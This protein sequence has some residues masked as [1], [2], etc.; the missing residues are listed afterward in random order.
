MSCFGYIA[1]IIGCFAVLFGTTQTIFAADPCAKTDEGCWRRE[2]AKVEAEIK[3]K[4]QVL[5]S[6]QLE[7][8]SYER[9]V[10]ILDAKIA[11]AQLKI[12]AKTISIEHLSQDIGTKL[13]TIDTLN[14]KI[15]SGKQSL[16]QLIRKTDE[17]DNI[18]IPEIVLGND[19]LSD[20]LADVNS[21]NSIKNALA[22]LFIKVRENKSST[23]AEKKILDAKKANEL[24]AKK[25]IEA[26]KKIVEQNEAKKRAL[27]KAAKTEESAYQQVINDRE[28]AAAQIRS[29]I[30]ALRDTDGIKFGDALAFAE[31][32]QKK[33]G[34]RPAFLLAILMQETNLGKNLGSCYLKDTTTGSGVGMNTGTP[35]AKVMKPDR[36]VQPFLQIMK[37]LGRDAFTTR[38]SCPQSIGYGGAMGPAQF[39][40]STWIM[41]SKSVA[42]G[43][44][45]SVADPWNP[46]D[47]FMASSMFLRDIGAAGG[48]YTGEMNAACRYF[49]GKVCSASAFAN[50]YGTQVMQKA[51][52]I[53]TTMIDPLDI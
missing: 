24:D 16:A 3:E 49:S 5:K 25:V 39:I 44:G 35:F 42:T 52:T 4:Q 31:E 23:E 21:Y 38:V 26:E 48:T 6:K 12:K 7:R 32:A 14:D 50:T 9:D 46:E 10:A 22:Q 8:T 41:Y 47:A 13:Q 36:D 17:L 51:T 40:P 2:L 18:T 15:E 28:K 19:N 1:A 45:R 53:Q 34:V 29:M 27:V 20:A 43:V 37:A 30:F 11:E 33:T